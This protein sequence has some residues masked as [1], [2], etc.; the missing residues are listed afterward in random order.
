MCARICISSLKFFFF[1]DLLS[2]L[3]LFC[4]YC[5]VLGIPRI[6]W[7]TPFIRSMFANIFFYFLACFLIFLTISF[8]EQ[9]FLNFDKIQFVF[10]LWIF[11][12]FFTRSCTYSTM[13]SSRNLIVLTFTIKTIIYFKL[14]F[15]ILY[16]A[17]VVVHY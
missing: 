10:L 11:L 7:K 3:L 13:F 4:S 16:E 8:L 17:C 12:L 1:S 14:I 6:L 9:N 2:N 15:C 5:W